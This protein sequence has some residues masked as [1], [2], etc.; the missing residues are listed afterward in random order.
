[1]NNDVKVPAVMSY[2]LCHQ[3]EFSKELIKISIMWY[4]YIREE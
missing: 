4:S 1:M 3:A 2:K